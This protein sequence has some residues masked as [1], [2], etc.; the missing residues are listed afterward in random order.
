M[1][2][3]DFPDQ[4]KKSLEKQNTAEAP[5][6]RRKSFQLGTA[7]DA[8]EEGYEDEEQESEEGE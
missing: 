3:D 7:S 4:L 5:A 1:S 2:F 8:R 6:Q